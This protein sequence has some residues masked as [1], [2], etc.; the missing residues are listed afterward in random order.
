MKK[1]RSLTARIFIGLIIGLI[2]GLIVNGLPESYFRDTVLINGVFLL[3]G[4]VFLRCIMMLVVPLVFVT[5]VNGVLNLGDVK[6]LGRIGGK[7]VIFYMCTTAIAVIISLVLANL[8]PPAAGVNFGAINEVEVTAREAVP[9]VE[10]LYNIIPKNVVAGF[11]EGNMLQV[12]AFAIFIGLGI[13]MVDKEVPTVR[14]FFEEMSEIMIRLI[15]FVMGFAPL[16]VF[17][18]IAKTFG[19]M[20]IAI[21]VPSIKICRLIYLGL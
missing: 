10:I 5:I 14:H 8:L 9:L 11:A 18:L 1:K 21:I 7:T 3:L 17:G 19:S 16:G 4:E 2:V 13:L 20:G 15:T 6:R 12:I